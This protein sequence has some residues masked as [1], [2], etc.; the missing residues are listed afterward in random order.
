MEVCGCFFILCRHASVNLNSEVLSILRGQTDNFE[1]VY[2][3]LPE[4]IL[5]SDCLYEIICRNCK[6]KIADSLE[7][8][9]KESKVGGNIDS[10]R[11][12]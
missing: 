5:Y 4:N 1:S 8:K 9:I 2:Q 7:T 12:G 6:T 11:H 10:D 3:A